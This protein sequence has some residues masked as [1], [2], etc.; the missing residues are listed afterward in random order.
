MEGNIG[1]PLKVVD[2]LEQLYRRGKICDKHYDAGKKFSDDF[3][4]ASLVGVRS[5]DFLGVHGGNARG[6]ADATL[7]ARDRVWRALTA[8]GAPGSSCAWHVLGLGETCAEYAAGSQQANG[9]SL[10]PQEATGILR[11]ALGNLAGFYQMG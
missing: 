2:S 1:N 8:L 10:H 9:R 11:G 3:A 6:P 4:R 7:Q 5:V